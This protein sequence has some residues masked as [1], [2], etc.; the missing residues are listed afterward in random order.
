MSGLIAAY[1]QYRIANL[2][3]ASFSAYARA[4]NTSVFD[5]SDILYLG[6]ANSSQHHNFDFEIINP[7]DQ[8]NYYAPVRYVVW[9]Y[10]YDNTMF[11]LYGHSFFDRKDLGP[12]TGIRF[13]FSAGYHSKGRFKLYRR[14]NV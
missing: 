10:K 8:V 5:M 12:I 1:S 13:F 3:Q 2:R 9:G 14:A 4:I 7:A 6:V 11:G